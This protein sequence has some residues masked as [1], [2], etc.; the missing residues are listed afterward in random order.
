ME[1]DGPEH[2]A[3]VRCGSAFAHTGARFSV[4]RR[5]SERVSSSLMSDGTGDARMVGPFICPTEEGTFEV[6]VRC[7]DCGWEA[8]DHD[9]PANQVQQ[10]IAAERSLF[11]E[12]TCRNSRL[13]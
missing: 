12:H 5:R 11:A 6:T 8:V 7:R 3:V 13:P 2:A 1:A 4:L 9:L 10:S